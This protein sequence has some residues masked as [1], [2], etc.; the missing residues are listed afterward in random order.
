MSPHLGHHSVQ[1]FALELR[2]NFLLKILSDKYIP[3]SHPTLLSTQ[4]IKASSM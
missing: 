2:M 3:K 4:E 1:E